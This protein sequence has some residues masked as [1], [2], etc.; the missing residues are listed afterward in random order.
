MGDSCPPQALA[1][2][3][4][5][6]P[7]FDYWRDQAGRDRIVTAD[8][9]SARY[10]EAILRNGA[11]VD[12]DDNTVKHLAGLGRTY[13]AGQYYSYTWDGM[14]LNEVDGP[15]ARLIQAPITNGTSISVDR[16]NGFVYPALGHY[17][18]L[19]YK[20]PHYYATRIRRDRS[21]PQWEAFAG[22][23]ATGYSGATD[24]TLGRDVSVDHIYAARNYGVHNGKV[25]YQF[26]DQ[27]VGTGFFNAMLKR[28][29]ISPPGPSG[30]TGPTGN[31]PIE[32]FA[33]LAVQTTGPYCDSSVVRQN[34]NLAIDYNAARTPGVF[35]EGD[36]DTRP[37]WLIFSEWSH[38]LLKAFEDDPADGK[39]LDVASVTGGSRSFAF[40]RDGRRGFIYFCHW[41][42]GKI[43]RQQIESI[44]GPIA[45]ASQTR[46][47][48]D[49]PVPLRDSLTTLQ[50]NG[51]AMR[52]DPDRQ[53]VI[54]TYEQYGLYGVAEYVD[55]LPP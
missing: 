9:I 30:P 21:T 29:T 38:T 7:S 6:L 19:D 1:A 40:R 46:E 14:T 45:L 5:Y 48:L 15:D 34:C 25:L 16:T 12:G 55:T 37:R 50:C 23:G 47:A 54:F 11:V 36:A 24:G 26:T 51:H 10:R 18:A 43:Y 13:W 4:G 2:R 22:G 8:S 28:F 49:W 52:Y 39:V 31:A 20:A 27:Y 3:F 32:H 53:S 33:G 42:E 17:T 44:S 41:T 35:D